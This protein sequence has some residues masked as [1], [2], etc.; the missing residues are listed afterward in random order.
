MSS[1]TSSHRA[2][3]RGTHLSLDRVMAAD[4]MTGPGR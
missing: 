1:L 3:T 4:A 2:V